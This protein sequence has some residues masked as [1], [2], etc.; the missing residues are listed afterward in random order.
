MQHPVPL[1]AIGVLI[2]IPFNTF[3]NGRFIITIAFGRNRRSKLVGHETGAEDV[4]GI[5][6]KN[7]PGLSINVAI[8]FRSEAYL[9]KRGFNLARGC[10]TDDG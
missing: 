8:I 3:T 5:C 2:F 4:F 1:N 10:L 7:Y 9:V 6:F